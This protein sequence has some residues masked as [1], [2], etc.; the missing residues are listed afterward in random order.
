MFRVILRPDGQS[1][2][3]Q[4]NPPIGLVG[5]KGLGVTQ[6]PDGSL[7]QV[8]YSVAELWAFIPSEA[9]TDEVRINSVWPRRGPEAGGST[10]TIYG[11]NLQQAGAST[12]V[13][14]GSS[15]CPV[16]SSTGSKVQCTLP[17]GSGRLDITIAVGTST[18]T[19]VKGY[20]FITGF[21]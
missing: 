10:L 1:V 11:K 2:I 18:Y 7:V 17:G 9:P 12:T 14:V 15:N 20:R 19:F 3:P 4:S 6:A 16:L 8:Q 21:R 13:T 5:K